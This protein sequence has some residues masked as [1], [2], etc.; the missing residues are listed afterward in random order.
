MVDKRA[1][2]ERPIEV[3]LV[4]HDPDDVHQT[5]AALR[6]NKLLNTLHVVRDGRAALAFL[7]REGGYATAPRPDLILWEAAQ[8]EAR[9]TELLRAIKAHEELRTIPLVVLVTPQEEQAVRGAAL[10]VDDYLTKPLTLRQ[11]LHVIQ[12]RYAVGF[13]V[14]SMAPETGGAAPPT[15]WW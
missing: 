5:R 2:R 1:R 11:L 3:L 13:I 12:A 8:L 9:G 14:V 15:R 6:A 4:A 7:R 10:P